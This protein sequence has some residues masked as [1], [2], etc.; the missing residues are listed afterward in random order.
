MPPFE[1]FYG[2]NPPSVLSYMLGVLKV[3]EVE[4][5]LTVHEAILH[6]LKDN[7]VMVQNHMKQQADQGHYEHHFV[8]GE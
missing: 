6:A 1:A 5:N 8:E 7:L 3:Q 4:K 2:Q